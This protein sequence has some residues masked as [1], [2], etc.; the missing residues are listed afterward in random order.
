MEVRS[1]V[2]ESS[3]MERCGMDEKQQTNAESIRC[4]EE[5]R[6]SNDA[7]IKKEQRRRAQEEHSPGVES[8]DVNSG[9]CLKLEAA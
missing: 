1:G 5:S 8:R 9:G 2:A 6:R 7:A 4:V 3:G